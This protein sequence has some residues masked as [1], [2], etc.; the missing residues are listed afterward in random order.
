MKVV[1]PSKRRGFQRSANDELHMDFFL[2]S[3]YRLMTIDTV[4]FE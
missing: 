3:Y 2:T 4:N 1:H